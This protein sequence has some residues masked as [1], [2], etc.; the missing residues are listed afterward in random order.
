MK[1][2]AYSQTSP[3]PVGPSCA[4]L[5]SPSTPH[6]RRKKNKHYCY[7]TDFFYITEFW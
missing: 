7:I 2:F 6:L 5:Q 1:N 4:L 3:A